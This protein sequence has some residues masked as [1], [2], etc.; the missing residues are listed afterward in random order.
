MDHV[1]IDEEFANLVTPLSEEEFDELEQSIFR[2]GCRDAL[3]VWKGQ[4][5]LLDGHHRY[6]ICSLNDIP[7]K[8]NEIELESREDAQIWIIK[9][10]EFVKTPKMALFEYVTY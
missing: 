3:G 5:I 2:H 10:D 4:N 6:Q 9:N 8:V 1:I 7:F